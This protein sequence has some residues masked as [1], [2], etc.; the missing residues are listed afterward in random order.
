MASD[1]SMFQSNAV[2]HHQALKRQL[3]ILGEI[4]LVEPELVTSQTV[5]SLQAICTNNCFRG[6]VRIHMSDSLRGHAFVAFGKLC[7]RREQLA[8]KSIE[9]LIHFLTV[10][11]EAI[12]VRN[13]ILIVLGDLA[14]AYTSLVDRFIPLITN[15]L[16]HESLLLRK[17]SLLI[18]SS[19]LAEDYIKFKGNIIHRLL[20]LIAD[21]A[22]EISEFVEAIFLR[23]LQPRNNLLF[24]QHFVET[25]CALNGWSDHPNFPGV[26]GGGTE[27]LFTLNDCED[28]KR[29]N[30]I[31]EFMLK[32]MTREQKYNVTN[33]LVM[34]FLGG[35]TD[36]FA[37]PIPKRDSPG[38]HALCDGFA[39]LS[40]KEVRICFDN[41]FNNLGNKGGEDAVTQENAGGVADQ[42]ANSST[43]TQGLTVGPAAGGKQSIQAVFK[44]HMVLIYVGVM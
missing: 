9:M 21:P 26:C 12:S 10:K 35:L 2:G 17:T 34:N 32:K 11:G 6:S 43:N 40:S 18:L 42:G 28:Y 29:R 23:I 27:T 4:A 38:G 25:I 15:F 36:E 7:L 3:F 39:I 31:Y 44:R 22:V 8:K 16:G 19:L 14:M 24:Q 20:F 37:A 41:R 13:N 30:R 1:L 33:S 5:M